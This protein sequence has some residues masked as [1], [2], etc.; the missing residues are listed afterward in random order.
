MKTRIKICCIASVA[1]AEMAIA[2]GADAV[3]LVARMPS[4]PGTISDERIAAIAKTIPP[5]VDSF[6]LT[7]ETDPGAVVE[8]VLLCKASVVQLVDDTTRETYLALREHSPGTRIVQ[9]I[10][11]EDQRALGQ[12]QEAADFVDAILLDSGRPSAEVPELGGTGR[13]HDWS[14][15]KQI[16]ASLTVP[17]FLAGGLHPDNVAK[18]IEQVSP[19]GVDLCSGVR[20]DGALD[21]VLLERFVKSV[22]GLD[23]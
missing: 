5:G 4:G 18:A 6:L 19:F 22:R 9:V 7:C 17:V 23:R 8:H 13:E 10:H 16:V 11:V 21:Q 1:E 14:I 12:A 3:G 20:T 2:A 15:S